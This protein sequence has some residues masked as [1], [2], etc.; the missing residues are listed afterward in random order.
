LIKKCWNHDPENRPTAEEINDCFYKYYRYNIIEENKE[1][2]IIELVGTKGQEIIKSYKFLS[3]TKNYRH[4]PELFYK[5]V[6]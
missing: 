4:H 6:Y 3:D 5:A 1:K 2:E